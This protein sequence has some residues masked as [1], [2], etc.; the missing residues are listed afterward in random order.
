MLKVKD[1]DMINNDRVF[2]GINKNG[3]YCVADTLIVMQITH[4]LILH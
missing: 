2:V 1:A 3:K 4:W